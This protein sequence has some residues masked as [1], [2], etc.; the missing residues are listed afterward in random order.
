MSAMDGFTAKIRVGLLSAAIA[1][2]LLPPPTIAQTMDHTKMKMPMPAQQ[3]TPPEQSASDDH[4]AVAASEP[5]TPIPPV[6]DADRAAAFAEITLPMEHASLVNHFVLLDRLEVWDAGRTTGQ[7][8]DGLA[9]VGTD[10][11]RLWLRSEGER[12]GSRTEAADL[13]AL[14]GRSV[15]PWWD[16]LVGVKHD[17]QPGNAQ[18]WL[19][20]GVQGLAPYKFEMQ[21]TAYVGES[22]RTL[23]RVEAEY[24]L[25]LSAR[26]ILQPRV[27]IN[28]YG[29]DDPQRGIGSGLGTSE[30]GLRLRWE[31]RREFAPYLGVVY[32]R[33]YGNT[34]DLRRVAGEATHDTRL[35]AGIRI[36]F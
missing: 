20:I 3:P 25:L 14:Y 17:F 30:I 34:A 29:K 12:V 5:R 11:H 26:L 16:L 35:V 28:A 7:T 22:G 2:V 10:I 15:S 33:A 27:E 36:W 1:F 4:A 21:A 31:W 32:E 18:D 24:E 13:E 23:A 6:S 9:W 8:W 19:A